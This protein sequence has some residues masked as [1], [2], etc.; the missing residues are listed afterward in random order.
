MLG[1]KRENRYFQLTKTAFGSE[2]LVR[3]WQLPD[4]LFSFIY[5]RY[6][7]PI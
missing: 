2:G 5:R 7:L 3:H 1:V 6:R 4:W